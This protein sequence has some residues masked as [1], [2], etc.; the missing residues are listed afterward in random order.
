MEY[1]CVLL[2]RFIYADKEIHLHSASY[3]IMFQLFLYTQFDK[4]FLLGNDY[5]QDIRNKLNEMIALENGLL[6]ER[7]ASY[8][9]TLKFTPVFLYGFVIIVLIFMYLAYA[10]INTNLEELRLQNHQ[11]NVFKESTKQ[12]EIINKHG[13]WRWNVDEDSFHFSDNLFRLLGE[14]PNA[15]EHTIENFMHFVH[16][17]DVKKLSD[18]IERMRHEKD[19]PF[20]TYRV[21]HNDGSIHYLKAYGKSTIDR[22]GKTQ[23]LG[24]TT[25]VTEDIAHYNTLELRNQELELNNKELAAFNYV[26]SHDLQEPLRKIQTFLSRLKEKESDRFSESG[27]TYMARI[28]VA[29]GRMR[30]LIDDLLQYSRTNKADA[31][32]KSS[33]IN[34]LISDAQQDLAEAIVEHDAQ[35]TVANM[36]KMLVVPFQIQQLFANLLNNSLKYRAKERAVIISIEYVLIAKSED[37]R[38]ASGHFAQYHKISFTDNGIGFEQQYAEKIFT[39]FSRLHNKDEYSGTGIGLSICKKITDNHAGFIFAKAA[40]DQGATF[41]IFLPK[42]Q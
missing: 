28:D 23:L 26:A 24:T 25:D 11:L 7:Q 39:L 35:I 2:Y 33:N 14:E 8:R 17:E 29:A 31:V 27:K 1:K 12:S 37:E 36:P 40:P 41:E 42:R 10:K 5:M 22:D 21:I 19:L 4:V 34:T 9:S 38:I 13:S 18:S 32:L 6:E 30:A 3:F 16:P 20:V 15:F